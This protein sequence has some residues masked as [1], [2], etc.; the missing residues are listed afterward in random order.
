[1][2]HN[3]LDMQNWKELDINTDS[4]WMIS[5]SGWS[6]L[7]V[8]LFCMGINVV[9]FMIIYFISNIVTAFL[10]S[11]ILLYGMMKFIDRKKAFILTKD[12]K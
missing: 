9:L 4:L 5:E 11:L 2:K 3:D 10:S 1:M 6:H 12:T 7:Q 8:S